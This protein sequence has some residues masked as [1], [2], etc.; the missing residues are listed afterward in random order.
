MNGGF[1]TRGSIFP[2]DPRAQAGPQP[3]D[4]QDLLSMVF[5]TMQQAQ[6]RRP[7]GQGPP[8][9]FDL[10]GAILNPGMNGRMGDAVWSQEAFDRILEQLAEQNGQ[11][12]A[13][14]PAAE[15]AIKSLETKK[16]DKEMMGSDGTAEC[17]I[18]MDAVEIGGEVTVFAMFPLVPR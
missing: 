11:S 17:S 15:S 5:Q 16:V 14:G 1:T 12:T 9:P 6:P 13:P 3:G 10:L 2:R 18:C 8:T 7:Q 4:M